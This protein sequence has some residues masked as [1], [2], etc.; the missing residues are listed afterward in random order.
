MSVRLIKAKRD[1]I[2]RVDI[3]GIIP[4]SGL[5]TPLRLIR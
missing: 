4:N 1:K 3:T 5:I 2:A